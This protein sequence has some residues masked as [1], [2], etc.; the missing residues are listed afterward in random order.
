MPEFI[1]NSDQEEA[2]RQAAA[3]ALRHHL[4]LQAL[5]AARIAQAAAKM[6]QR[7]RARQ[8]ALM[9]PLLLPVGVKVRVSFLASSTVRQHVKVQMVKAFSPA[10]SKEVYVITD[11][12]LAPG[13]RRVV[14]Y[15]VRVEDQ[16]IAD[17]EQ[18]PTRIAH[19]W[20]R[21]PL[22][23]ANLDRRYLQ[24]LP[25][26]GVVPTSSKRYEHAMVFGPLPLGRPAIAD[27]D[28]DDAEAYE[29][30]ESAVS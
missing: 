9:R 18:A 12:R 8:A 25:D 21:L 1:E 24:P 28:Y 10:Y 13:S 14:L 15:D 19:L 6:V 5:A 22:T 7:R 27:D 2:Q 26:A 3:A 29:D 4:D 23:I 17:G 16:G 11:R 30:L 20:V